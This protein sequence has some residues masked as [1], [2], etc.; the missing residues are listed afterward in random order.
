M[1]TYPVF[2]VYGIKTFFRFPE[3]AV[4]LTY[5]VYAR[6]P[7]IIRERHPIPTIDNVLYNLN[8]S[9]IF[10][11]ID[12]KSAFH[13]IEL[14]VASRPITTFCSSLGLFRYKRLMFGISCVPEIFQHIILQVI[15]KCKGVYNIHDDIIVTGTNRS[16][17]FNCV[18]REVCYETTL[19]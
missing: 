16:E 18:C 10:S 14:D 2:A 7:S 13:Q 17:W 3:N 8:G 4:F 15:S 1:F 11:K 5:L 19:N 12:L 6:S 9:T